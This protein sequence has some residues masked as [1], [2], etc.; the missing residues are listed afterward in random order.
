MNSSLPNDSFHLEHQPFSRL[1]FQNFPQ[2][3]FPLI[4][5]SGKKSKDDYMQRLYGPG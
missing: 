4:H 2:D 3:H 1:A 5:Q